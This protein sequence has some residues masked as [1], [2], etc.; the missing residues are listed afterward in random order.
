MKWRGGM[1][2]VDITMLAV[3][4]GLIAAIGFPAAR[5][6][7]QRAHASRCA[8]N[9]EALAM[10]AQ[11]YEADHGQPPG[12]IP[13][14]IPDYLTTPPLCPAAGSYALGAGDAPPTCTIPGHQF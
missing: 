13:A 11:R 5:R 1:T 9:L 2:A 4:V 8:M 14:L 6:N 12:A 10:A 7:R 3:V